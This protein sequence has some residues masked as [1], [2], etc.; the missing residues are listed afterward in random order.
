MKRIIN[1]IIVLVLFVIIAFGLFFYQ[2]NKKPYIGKITYGYQ[3]WPG[4][5]PYL[6]AYDLGFFKEQGLE[7]KMV[8]EDSYVQEID[9]LISGKTD[10]I[11]DIALID[12]VKK[13]SQ[14]NKLKV[15]LATDYSN[16]ADGIVVKKEIKTFGDLK[17]KKVAV[18]KDTLSEYL[19]YDAL[20]KNDL[21]FND[22]EE[23]DLSSQKGAEAFIK[24]E[25]DAVVTYEPELSKAVSN[26][27]GYSLY[28]S[29][30]SPGLIIDVLAFRDE[31]MQKNQNKVVAV[32]K[33][34]VKAMDYIK[35][36]P[37]KSY[38]I[39]AKYFK[40][41]SEEF[42][43]QLAGIKLLN[44]EDNINALSY[45][46]SIN[47][48]HGAIIQANKFLI[49]KQSIKNEVDSIDIIEPKFIRD[50]N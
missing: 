50:L 27:N 8:K 11:G 49:E 34:Y 24:G 9:N 13:A 20:K 6:V 47:S 41:T 26:G 32:V 43:N 15:V 40:I 35:N 30:N 5:L 25:V 46:A 33:A 45:G 7:V 21:N 29:L 48:L 36:N 31:F 4:V 22:I 17:S 19:L 44:K 16:G 38:I 10:F 3:N 37:D 1:A 18:E 14:G 12:V 39:G 2:Q 28:T 42:K 23:I